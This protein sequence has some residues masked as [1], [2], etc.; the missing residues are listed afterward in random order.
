MGICDP[1]SCPSSSLSVAGPGGGLLLSQITAG[2]TFKR[3]KIIFF[4]S[5]LKL[6]IAG[7]AEEALGEAALK[8][9]C[10]YSSEE[11][12]CRKSMSW[13]KTSNSTCCFFVFK[14]KK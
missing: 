13:T 10:Y 1:E 7:G 12:L 8:I 9:L 5:Q 6:E 2:L 3:G 11:A 14:L 4:I